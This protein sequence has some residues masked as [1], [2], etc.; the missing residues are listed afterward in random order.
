MKILVA[1][2]E[3]ITRRN[4]QRHLEKWGHEV[5]T[6][7]NG[8]DAWDIFQEQEI[9]ILIT[10]WVMPEMDGLTLVKKIRAKENTHYTYTILLTSKSEKVDI[11][12]GMEAGADD[13]LSKP[14]DK[15]ELNVRLRAGIRIIELEQNLEQQNQELISAN[16]QVIKWKTRVQKEIALAIDVQQQFLP[17]M[18]E[19]SFPIF[20]IN[21]PA[22]EIS[23]DFYDIVINDAGNIYFA[24]GDVAGKGIHAGMV[25][26]QVVSLFRAYARA[27]LVPSHI[28]TTMNLELAKTSVKG[29]FTTIIVGELDITSKKMIYA[30]AGHLPPILR[31][32]NGDIIKK[33][34]EA[35]PIG[36][37][38]DTK[39]NEYTNYEIDL[40]D[41]AFYI[42]SDGI[43]EAKINGVQLG[44]EGLERLINQNTTQYKRERIKNIL[45]H[46]SHDTSDDL[47][48][49]VIEI[50]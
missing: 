14:F 38:V 41:S 47:T 7:E 43:V 33:K 28:L 22:V 39:M 48:L 20:A 24:L 23:G 8:A 17:K 42:Y 36:I 31:K 5:I 15:N 32:S 10:D 27:G 3:R 49:M 46:I 34:S 12:E 40:S 9:P 4:I 44:V 25:M 18:N 19:E 30:N 45:S 50:N 16:E 2:D 21:I 26:A 1:D 13:F 29:M 11:V 6:A 35:P 37:I